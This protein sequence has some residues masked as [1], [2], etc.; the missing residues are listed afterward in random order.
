MIGPMDF[1]TSAVVRDIPSGWNAAGPPRNLLYPDN[2]DDRV[3][4]E[5]RE[6]PPFAAR[7]SKV[8]SSQRGDHCF[9]RNV[10]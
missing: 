6:E 2:L 8:V 7:R 1:C 10:Q 5:Q 9:S 3:I 4:F